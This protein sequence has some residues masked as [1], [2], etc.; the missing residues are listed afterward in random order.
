MVRHAQNSIRP[1][2]RLPMEVLAHIFSYLA[3]DMLITEPFPTFVLNANIRIQ[4]Y[5]AIAGGLSSL[6]INVP[7]VSLIV[8]HICHTFLCTLLRT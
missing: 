1:I 4:G 7:F 8:Q 6:A 3:E 5:F 2:N